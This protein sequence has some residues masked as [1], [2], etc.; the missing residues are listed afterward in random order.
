MLLSLGAFL[1]DLAKPAA[2]IRYFIETPGFATRGSGSS[3]AIE[4]QAPDAIT[5]ID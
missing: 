4:Q 5:T 1:K 3:F 2:T